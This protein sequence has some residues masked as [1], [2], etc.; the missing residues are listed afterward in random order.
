MQNAILGGIIAVLF[1][2]GAA[3]TLAYAQMDPDKVPDKPE[4]VKPSG[5]TCVTQP[6][7]KPEPATE[8]T[9]LEP[10]QTSEEPAEVSAKDRRLMDRIA[11]LEERA[12]DAKMDLADTV[13]HQEKRKAKL[14]AKIAKIESRITEL[15]SRIGKDVS[16]VLDLKN[17]IVRLVERINVAQAELENAV[18]FSEESDNLKIKIAKMEDRKHDLDEIRDKIVR[19]LF[20][21]HFGQ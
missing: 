10:E 9:E 4:C 15:E 3:G 11:I 20:L 18:P 19:D 5:D 6:E 17:R 21:K 2:V 1:V 14:E 13:E 12:M 8:P 7:V 16:K